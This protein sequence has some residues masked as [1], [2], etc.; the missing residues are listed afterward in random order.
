M[1]NLTDKVALVTGG[2]ASARLCAAPRASDRRQFT[3][4]G[5]F[6]A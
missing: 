5:G 4:D 3:I 2:S 1:A 6:A